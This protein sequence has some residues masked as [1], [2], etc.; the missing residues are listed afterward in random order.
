MNGT[1]WRSPATDNNKF[2]FYDIREN[3]KGI[4]SQIFDELFNTN[5]N[6]TLRHNKRIVDSPRDSYSLRSYE[7]A[8][9]P[10]SYVLWHAHKYVSPRSNVNKNFFSRKEKINTRQILQCS[11]ITFRKARHG[12]LNEKKEKKNACNTFCVICFT[13]IEKRG[14]ASRDLFFFRQGFQYLNRRAGWHGEIPYHCGNK[15][16][17]TR[18]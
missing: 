9:S 6:S 16:T 10:I 11:A 15:R 2:P 1:Q 14:E 3:R 13:K 7:R 5:W 12:I 17:S 18:R 4:L 8:I